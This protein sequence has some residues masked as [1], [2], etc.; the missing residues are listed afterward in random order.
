MLHLLREAG[1][2][3][4]LEHY[5]DPEAIPARNIEALRKLGIEQLSDELT[6]LRQRDS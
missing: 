2:E 3:R 6:S 1:L 5:P 4:A